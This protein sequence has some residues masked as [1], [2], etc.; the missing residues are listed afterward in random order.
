MTDQKTPDQILQ[1]NIGKHKLVLVIGFDE[2]G[3]THLDTNRPTFEFVNYAANRA[4]YNIN[5]LET[6][7]VL[8]ASHD[9]QAPSTPAEIAVAEQVSENIKPKR[10]RP[11]KNA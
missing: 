11:K 3:K 1:D 4:V 10:G 5:H 8:Q 6:T 7:Q 9:A 2:I